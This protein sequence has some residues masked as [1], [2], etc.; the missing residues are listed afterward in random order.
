MK[1]ASA[2][3]DALQVGLL[4]FVALRIASQLLSYPSEVEPLLMDNCLS[5][6]IKCHY[7]LNNPKGH[8]GLTT[9]K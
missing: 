6:S 1:I 4:G 5:I 7:G 9:S 3:P 8:G 2:P